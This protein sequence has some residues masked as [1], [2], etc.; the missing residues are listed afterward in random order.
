[1]ALDHVPKASLTLR[2]SRSSLSP[3]VQLTMHFLVQTDKYP[4][5]NES[6]TSVLW[7]Q[8]DRFQ[9]FGSG[10]QWKNY[11]LKKMVQMSKS[12]NAAFV[13]LKIMSYAV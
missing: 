7:S 11:R 12:F 3:A 4:M 8:N 9:I 13:I 2:M 10:V 5:Q 1:M 6:L